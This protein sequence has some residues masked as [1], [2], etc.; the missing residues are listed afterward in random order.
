MNR[1]ELLA[2]YKEP[3]KIGPHGFVQ[4]IDVMGNDAAICEAA[5]TSYGDGTKTVN[6]DRNLIRRL[7]RDKHTSPFEMCE[8]KFCIQAP[9]YILRQWLRHR[10]ANVNEYSLRYSESLDLYETTA[11]N[12]WRLQSRSNKQGSN[13]FVKV[14]NLD[15]YE[16]HTDGYPL[17]PSEVEADWF[18]SGGYYSEKENELYTDIR[19]RY[20]DLLEKGVARE[21]ARK[22]LP[23]STYSRCYWKIDL[24]NLL[25][26][27]R[28]RLDPHA[29]QEI[30]EFAEAIWIIINDWTPDSAMAFRDYVLEAVTFSGPEIRAMN[31]IHNWNDLAE[32]HTGETEQIKAIL[33]TV[34][35]NVSK[36]ER[37][38]FVKKLK[39]IFTYIEDEYEYSKPNTD[40]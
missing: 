37:Q 18:S 30:R 15:D 10:T 25:H 4:L 27:L 5:R 8:I 22:I 7:M 17:D 3:I 11:E 23:L 20:L 9:I 2:K 29:Q 16:K 32:F 26:F 35:P 36:T 6:D 31:W 19:N 28:L 21:Q 33:D 13:G 24:H 38:E 39:T 12:E 40:I 1:E 34:L 14:Q